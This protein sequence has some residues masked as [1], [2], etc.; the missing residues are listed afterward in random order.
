MS[1][2]LNMRSWVLNLEAW[3]KYLF[4]HLLLP[5]PTLQCL[6]SKYLR[7]LKETLMQPLENR[8][9]LKFPWPIPI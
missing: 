3:F 6:V 7:A 1:A 8:R 5:K 9:M 2:L 4:N